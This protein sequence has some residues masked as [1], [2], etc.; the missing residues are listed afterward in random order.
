[1]TTVPI[2]ISASSKN[3]SVHVYVPRSFVGPF[4]ISS[5]N[6]SLKRSPDVSATSTLFFESNGTQRGFIGDHSLT[7]W[8]SDPSAW[9]GDELQLESSNGSCKIY[10]VDEADTSALTGKGSGGKG[11]FNKLFG[12]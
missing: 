3:G 10:Y 6:G 1:M 12:L 7:D 4:T 9:K 11:F 5:K 2:I 8:G